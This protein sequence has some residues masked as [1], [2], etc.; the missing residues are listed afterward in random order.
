MTA[1]RIRG[2]ERQLRP[3]DWKLLRT[4]SILDYA[5]TTQLQRACFREG[6]PLARARRCRRALRRLTRLHVLHRLERSIGGP[7]GGSQQGIYTLGLGGWR[8]LELAQDVQTRARRSP[9]ERGRA[10][11]DHTLAV[12]A[13]YVDL[14]E[15]LRVVGGHLEDWAPEP[16]CY[17]EFQH[18][19]RTERLTPDAYIEV[20]VGSEIISSF[21]EVDRGTESMPTLV[22]KCRTYLRYARTD[23]DS[24]QVVF[25]LSSSARAGRLQSMVKAVASSEG[26]TESITTALIRCVDPSKSTSLLSGTNPTTNDSEDLGAR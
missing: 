15:H 10:F 14:V 26:L 6:T 22:R 18:G 25:E 19:A 2:L 1:A 24:P 17:R 7:T 4:L 13:V 8:L 5:T 21:L 16:D 11:P 20:A 9:E 3:G 12:S 23:S